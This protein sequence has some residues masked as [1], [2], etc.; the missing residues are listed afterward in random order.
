MRILDKILR[1]C[2][3]ATQTGRHI[4]WS[5]FTMGYD[6]GKDVL[7]GAPNVNPITWTR[8]TSYVDASGT[9]GRNIAQ[10]QTKAETHAV[11]AQ[12]HSD[13]LWVRNQN[14]HHQFLECPASI[15]FT[16]SFGLTSEEC[17]STGSNHIAAVRRSRPFPI[18]KA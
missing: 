14:A 13:Y 9:L 10:D 11:S 8:D 7:R 2:D 12:V 4:T 18:P 1:P 17:S 16:I 15:G 3:D 5:S 6:P